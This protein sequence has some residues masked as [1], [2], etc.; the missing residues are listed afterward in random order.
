MVFA[1]YSEALS[2]EPIGRP[3]KAMPMSEAEREETKRRLIEY[4]EKTLP[5]FEANHGYLRENYDDLLKQ[6]PD[7]F[8]AVHERQV[9][10]SAPSMQEI[11]NT[12]DQ[13]GID[14]HCAVF[15]FMNTGFSSMV[16]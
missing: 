3:P 1:L 7:Q 6:Y 5:A 8:I 4:A 13:L 11:L 9:V 12:V 14:R 2:S 16:L 10:A 15:E